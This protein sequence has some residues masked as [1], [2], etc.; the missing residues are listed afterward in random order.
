MSETLGPP[1]LS[2][3]LGQDTAVEV[4]TALAS[5]A[6]GGDPVPP[7]LLCGPEGVGKR[8]AALAFASSLACRQRTGTDACGTC[9]P[10]R[11][12]AEAEAVTA[13]REG[14]TAQ[15]APRS[16]PD[17]GLVSIPRGKTRI[18][19]LQARDIAL[20]LALQPFELERRIYLVDPADALTPGAANAL[21]KVLEEPPPYGVLMLV[22][23]APWALPITVRSRLRTILFRPLPEAVVIELL[24]GEG[25]ETGEAGTRARRAA[26]S[27]ARARALDLEGEAKRLEAWIQILDRLAARAPAPPLA[28]LA[29]EAFGGSAT[30][31]LSGLAVLLGALRDVAAAQV[32]A[33]PRALP[34][35]VAARLAPA[36]TT[37]LGP[38]LDRA[39]AIETLRREIVSINRNPRLGVEGAVLALAG[40]LS[41]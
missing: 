5:R 3:V 38:A 33:A 41:T 39:E 13:L 25:M 18:S 11:R 14:A 26:G 22:T 40:A 12:M 21:L 10:C 23:T 35:E 37:L 16:Y 6:L 1:P 29:G 27:L 2:R 8:T 34:P 7:L 28:V 31:A 24:A 17:S 32:G 9:G 20:S 15:D 19:V 4:L 36:A 30:E